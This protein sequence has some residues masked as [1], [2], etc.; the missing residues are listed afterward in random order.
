MAFPTK[1]IICLQHRSYMVSHCAMVFC[2][3]YD[4]YTIWIFTSLVFAV[5]LNTLWFMQ[6]KYFQV[7]IYFLDN[8]DLRTHFEYSVDPW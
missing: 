5:L 7:N 4:V 2:L 6:Y 8:L 3:G 1:V